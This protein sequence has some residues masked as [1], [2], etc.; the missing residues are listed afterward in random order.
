MGRMPERTSLQTYP[1]ATLELSCAK[2][3]RA[4]TESVATLAA[5]FGADIRLADLRRHLVADCHL[6]AVGRELCGA[7]FPALADRTG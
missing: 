1:G 5:R 4:V 7:Y 3:E 2:C 6:N